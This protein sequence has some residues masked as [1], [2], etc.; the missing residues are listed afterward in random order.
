MAGAAS[1][2]FCEIGSAACLI[3]ARFHHS[4][5]AIAQQTPVIA[6]PSNTPK[7]EATVEMLGLEPR[8]Y[9]TEARRHPPV[10]S[11]MRWHGT[12]GSSQRV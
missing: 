1:A 6:F 5:A 11:T 4:L 7:V 10:R 8:S 3:S 12:R 9:S 2:P